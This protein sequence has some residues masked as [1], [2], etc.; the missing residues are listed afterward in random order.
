MDCSASGDSAPAA[1]P[2]DDRIGD[3]DDDSNNRII[4]AV[5]VCAGDV[6]VGRNQSPQAYK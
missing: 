6:H 2:V 5:H 1:V 3:N 4:S